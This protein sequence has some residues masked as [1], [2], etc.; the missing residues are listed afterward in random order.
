M[1]SNSASASSLQN[2]SPNVNPADVTNLQAAFAYQSERLKNYQEQLTKL[3]LGFPWLSTHDPD[4]SWKSGELTRWSNFCLHNC[5]TLKPQPCF[6]TS[7]ESPDNPKPINLPPCYQDLSEVFS[8]TKATQLPPH[9][10]W[11]CS[12]DLLPNAMP[13]KSKSQAMEDYITEALDSGFIRPSTSPAAAGFFFVEKKD[14]GLRPCIDYRGLNNVTVKFCYPLPLV[15]A[16]LE[17]L[18]EATIYTKL[19]LRSAYNLIRIK[20]G[21]EWKTV[22]LT[23]RGHYEYQV[24]P[25]GLANSPAVFQSFINEIFKDILN[26]YVIAYIDDILIYSKTEAE[27]V[28]HVRTVLSRLLENQLYVKAEKCEF[29]VP[30]TTFLGYQVSPHGVKMDTTKVK[31]V[32]EWPQPTTIKELQRF[33]GFANFYRRFIRNYSTVASPLTALLKGKP[34]KLKWTEEVG[35][36]F[37]SL[38]ERFTPA[39]RPRGRPLGGILPHPSTDCHRSLCCFYSQAMYSLPVKYCQF[40][41]PYQAF[42]IILFDYLLLICLDFGFTSSRI[43]PLDCMPDWTVFSDSTLAC[44]STL[45]SWFALLF[46]L[47]LWTVT[48]ALTLACLT[49]LI[50]GSPFCSVVCAGLPFRF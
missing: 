2:T 22:F 23:T 29:H 24:M 46:R 1:D 19:D 50:T 7:I 26:Q 49:L 30:Q 10:P 8:K 5:L 41:L 42:F 39:P 48:L 37:A 4:F 11:D 28:Q 20:E 13:P 47:P 44:L 34:K 12:I 17:Q 32:T 3:I 14:G 15:P 16:A 9:R 21:D 33:L 27:H 36:A 18:R 35:Q 31:A 25:Y 43:Y 6:T 45:V 40:H 38:K